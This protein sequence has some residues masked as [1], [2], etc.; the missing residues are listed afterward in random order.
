MSAR[1]EL[2]GWS[3]GGRGRRRGPPPAP[4]R[5][6]GGGD[7]DMMAGRGVVAGE[8]EGGSG[9]GDA[10]GEPVL[11]GRADEDSSRRSS[12]RGAAMALKAS[13]KRRAGLARNAIGMEM[14]SSGVSGRRPRNRNG[15]ACRWGRTRPR[16]PPLATRL[17]RWQTAVQTRARRRATALILFTC[18]NSN[19]LHGPKGI[20]L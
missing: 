12:I 2:I 3:G 1:K 6:G 16:P 19:Q 4:P 8:G 15:P 17:V 18:Y 20:W 7:D 11:G 14:N 10:N 13:G 5:G 9:G